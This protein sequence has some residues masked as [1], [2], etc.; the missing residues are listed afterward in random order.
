MVGRSPLMSSRRQPTTDPRLLTSSHRLQYSASW[1]RGWTQAGSNQHSAVGWSGT[2]GMFRCAHLVPGAELRMLLEAG[3]W[4]GVRRARA[5]GTPS[6]GGPTLS[7]SNVFA[8][9]GCRLWDSK[10][11]SGSLFGADRDIPPLIP[12][13]ILPLIVGG[14]GEHGRSWEPQGFELGIG[15]CG[16]WNRAREPHLIDHLWPRCAKDRPPDH[17]RCRFGPNIRGS[18]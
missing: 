5:S 8:S 16:C 11:G 10:G 15:C 9:Q 14:G 2:G 12:L 1:K 6:A 13:L 17:T 3:V 18:R 7:R 4:R